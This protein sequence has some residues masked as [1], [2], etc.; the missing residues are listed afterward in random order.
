MS[1]VFT[2]TPPPVFEP[3]ELPSRYAKAYVAIITA[4]VAGL[5]AGLTDGLTLAEGLGVGVLVLN[6]VLVELVPLAPS[7][8]GHYS[9]A[10]IAVLAAA[11]Q[12]VIPLVIDGGQ[13]STSGWMLVLLAA[14]GAVSVGITPNAPQGASKTIEISGGMLNVSPGVVLSAEEVERMK[15]RFMSSRRPEDP[16]ST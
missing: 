10:I 12:A 11:A 4:L 1:N 14:L 3:V 6:A 2:T 9:K 15:T 7:G 16:L 5:Y 13:I 8:V